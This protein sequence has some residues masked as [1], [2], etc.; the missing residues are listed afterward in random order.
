MPKA[1]QLISCGV[2]TRT[3][4]PRSQAKTL[5]GSTS[6]SRWPREQFQQKVT[7]F[8]RTRDL[9]LLPIYTSTGL[10]KKKTPRKE[11]GKRKLEMLQLHHSYISLE[12]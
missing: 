6:P 7:N 2:R 10:T 12:D 5:G 8:L 1:T 3:T 11:K 4:C 9:K